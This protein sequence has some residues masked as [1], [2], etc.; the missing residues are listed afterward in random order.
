MSLVA[1]AG[2]V[3]QA[4]TFNGNPLSLTAGLATLRILHRDPSLYRRMDEATR[5][6]GESIPRSAKGSFVRLGSMFKYFFRPRPPRDYRE[7]KECDTAAFRTFWEQMLRQ[8]IFLPPSQF[9]TN[10]LSAAHGEDE[11]QAIAGSY[12]ACLSG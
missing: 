6:I 12:A 11:I 10:F 5:A 4:G 2:P 3:Y 1:P 7:A 9:E 8:G